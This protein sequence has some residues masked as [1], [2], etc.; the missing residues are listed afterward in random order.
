[1]CG[2]C[3]IALSTRSNRS[4]DAATIVRMRD[5]MV[6]RGPDGEGLFVDHSVALAHRRLSIVDV[7]HGNLQL[8]YNGEVFNHPTLSA[9]LQASGVH[10]RTHCDTETVLHIFERERYETP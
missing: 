3:G 8:V 5:T 7:A 2:I 9:E 10:Y 1:M 4:V 6:H